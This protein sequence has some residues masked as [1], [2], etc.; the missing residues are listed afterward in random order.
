MNKFHLSLVCIALSTTVNAAEFTVDQ[1]DK[2]FTEQELTI[3]A[4][5]TVNFRNADSFSHNVYSLSETKSFD[6]GSYAKGGPRPVTFDQPGV[7][8][9]GCAIHYDMEMKI[10]VK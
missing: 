1:K 5:D 9:V 8:E 10:I 4:G 3:S 2:M 6:L 7:I